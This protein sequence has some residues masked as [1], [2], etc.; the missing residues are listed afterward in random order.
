M[1]EWKKTKM[2][3]QNWLVY[4]S[5]GLMI[6]IG[7]VG[8]FFKPVEHHVL[9]VEQPAQEVF[10]WE[11]IYATYVG[12]TANPDYDPEQEVATLITID[13]DQRTI[14]HDAKAQISNLSEVVAGLPNVA[15]LATFEGKSLVCTLDPELTYPLVGIYVYRCEYS[16]Q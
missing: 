4:G 2:Q 5:L 7:F 11:T 13:R 8:W 15:P 14:S 9:T 6:L 10:G 1:P 16:T 12:N 3:K